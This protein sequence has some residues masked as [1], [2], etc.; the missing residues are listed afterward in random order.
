[1]SDDS[2][3]R[4]YP[5]RHDQSYWLE[6]GKILPVMGLPEK[7]KKEVWGWRLGTYDFALDIQRSTVKCNII[8]KTPAAPTSF[9]IPFTSSGLTREGL[10]F[11]HNGEVVG[12]MR[13]PM[14]TD[15]E[16][17]VREV[18]ISF[19]V[20]EITLNLD[21]A[22]LAYPIRIDPTWQVGQD[23]DDF[24]RK[25]V[26]D[27][28]GTLIDDLEVG[29]LD[30]TNYRLGGGMRFT[31]ITIPKD[32]IIAE[33]Y[34]IF[35]CFYGATANVVNS[36][37]SA[38]KSGDAPTFI[39]DGATFD[40]RYGNRTDARVDWDAIPDWTLDEDYNSPEIKTVIQEI[41]NRGDWASGNAIAIFWE[42]FEDRSTRAAGVRRLAYAHHGSS[43][44]CPQL[45]ITT[46]APPPT[47][48]N[49]SANMA[50]KILVGQAAGGNPGNEGA[51][52]LVEE[53]NVTETVTTV[54]FTDLDI[55]TDKLYVIEASFH[56]PSPGEVVYRMWIN[57]DT[58]MENYTSQYFFAGGGSLFAARGA[59][60]E[61]TNAKAGH[62]S[63]VIAS[64]FRDALG[65]ARWTTHESEWLPAELLLELRSD[66]KNAPVANI[67][68]LDIEGAPDAI[69][70]GSRI[71]L[72]KVS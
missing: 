66:I 49:K 32:A 1:M 6:F 72:F 43:T 28:F 64:L 26:P 38:E 8:L 13:Q 5:D 61:L 11:K 31:N 44:Y 18:G 46:G 56:N 35:R 20:G 33:A 34:L 70:A 41:V 68:R 19:G 17:N 54:T 71:R 9:T 21:T 60:N 45:V 58:T 42:D 57:G 27:Y 65:Y 29:A 7:I 51:L 23:T 48:E 2:T 25:L 10:A 62:T 53:V 47:L 55:N 37:I 16:G 14:A 15:V 40:A 36:R 22:G 67:T 3:R 69:G 4:I 12:W 24:F 63:V 52:K 39:N 50:A 59:S 30:A